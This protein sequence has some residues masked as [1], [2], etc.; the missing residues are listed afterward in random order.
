MVVTVGDIPTRWDT[1]VGDSHDLRLAPKKSTTN[2]RYPAAHREDS[3]DGSSM[4]VE[5]GNL[6]CA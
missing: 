3:W 1:R 5:Y 2:L 6:A 4:Y